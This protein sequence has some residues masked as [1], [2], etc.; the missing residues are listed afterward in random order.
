MTDEMEGELEKKRHEL[1][2]EAEKHRRERDKLNDRARDWIEKRDSLNAKANELASNATECKK[3][4][5][6]YNREV[7][8]AKD[9]RD[10]WNHVYQRLEDQIDKLKK[11]K[12]PQNMEP[13][14][15]LRIELQNLEFKQMTSVMS[16]GDEK[17]LIE[18][19][20]KIQKRIKEI[21]QVLE[22]D[23]EIITLME[24][25]R[26]AYNEAEKNHR[27]VEECAD[28]AQE[29]HD[30]MV[31]LYDQS[32]RIRREAD[33]AQENFISAKLAADEEHRKHVELIKQ[34]HDYD[35]MITGIKQ[36]EKL[37]K[38]AKEDDVVKKQ[39]ED[40]Y[41]RFKQGEKLS[42]EDLMALQKAG[43]L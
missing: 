40:I 22:K 32:D 13:P 16:P 2:S 9:E 4:R 28:K 3:K 7:R 26:A 19:M 6:E 18:R 29:A 11:K 20:S 34:V 41:S 43:Y 37:S 15:R 27:S 36:K 12:T 25:M 38:R 35:K 17:A 1:N 5:D 10:K 33:S 14:G 39:A 21:E 30:R 8:K 24:E 31:E 23:E 42:T